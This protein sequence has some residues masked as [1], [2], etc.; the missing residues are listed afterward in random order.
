MLILI[1]SVLIGFLIGAQSDY[2]C[3]S[4]AYNSYSMNDKTINSSFGGYIHPNQYSID[5]LTMKS[6][7]SIN[8]SSRILSA[9]VNLKI[10][11]KT[12]IDSLHL[13]F[14]KEN[15]LDV[16]SF[17]VNGIETPFQRSEYHV[18][19]GLK[20]ATTDTI[21][22][23]VKYSGKIRRTLDK[24]FCYGK[25]NEFPIYFTNSQP[26]Y[27][28]YWLIANDIP[29]DKVLSSISIENDSAFVSLSN[30]V[31]TEYYNLGDRRVYKYDS[32]YPIAPYLMV[33]YS[34]PY[35]KI[36]DST[37]SVSGETIRLEY[38]VNP[39]KKNELVNKLHQHKQWMKFFEEKIGPYP[40]REEKYGVAEFLWNLG[41]M[42]NQTIT[43]VGSIFMTEKGFDNDLMIHELVHSWWGNSVTVEYWDDIWLHEG[44][45]TYWA[46]LAV[47][48]EEYL[49]KQLQ[50]S[51]LE[52]FEGSVY[53]PVDDYFGS[54]VY[55]KG[56]WVLH[57]MRMD[58]GDSMFY[59]IMQKFYK[60]HA[61]NSVTTKDFITL[62]ESETKRDWSQ[63]FE[64]WV[65]A[66]CDRPELN[67]LWCYQDS[68]QKGVEI[69]VKQK[70][71]CKTLFKF[72]VPIFILYEDGTSEE[73][74]YTVLDKEDTIIIQRNKIIKEIDF[75][76]Q[77]T[78]L[79][80]CNYRFYEK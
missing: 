23:S 74:S 78:I 62:V 75:D 25:L 32:R 8:P 2:A 71:L 58:V 40:F 28:S 69:K 50:S 34:A 68:T 39:K 36:I 80:N 1:F 57:M 29:S 42:E 48:D 70:Q 51:S 43:G 73:I 7:F 14:R 19:V 55:D 12:Y 24:G 79:M 37:L 77:S 31:Q 76:P 46:L 11:F 33:I 63:F 45:A 16:E 65:F 54:T 66:A 35:S 6:Y 41:A 64:Q 30:G 59:H 20:S 47:E 56:A 38:Y 4:Y 72:T 27:S 15:M 22:V 13:N 52:P 60:E 5:V 67:F 3:K 26:N 49:R 9:E 53:A 44:F 21:T 17:K 10:T 61:Y 18:A